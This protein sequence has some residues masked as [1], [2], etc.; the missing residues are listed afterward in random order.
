MHSWT[1]GPSIALIMDRFGFL[2]T[3]VDENPWVFYPS[4]FVA[5]LVGYASL[6]SA[7]RF[8]RVNGFK[9]KHGFHDRE[10]LSQMTNEQAHSIVNAA[11]SKEFPLFYDLALRVALFK[12]NRMAD[13]RLSL[14]SC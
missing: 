9:A 5:G 1:Q 7:L 6:C 10:S 13:S 8:R 14:S 12:V 11:G 3:V 2:K 4:V